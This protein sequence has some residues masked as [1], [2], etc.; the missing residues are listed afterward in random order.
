MW[1]DA[2]FSSSYLKNTLVIS[3]I[4]H[5]KAVQSAV[6]MHEFHVWRSYI[7]IH[8]SCKRLSSTYIITTSNASWPD[9]S[10]V[11][12]IYRHCRRKG[13]EAPGRP[14]CFRPYLLLLIAKIIQWKFITSSFWQ[15]VWGVQ[16]T[17]TLVWLDW[18]KSFLGVEIFY[19]L[20]DSWK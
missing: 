15:F 4:I 7:Q 20:E 18:R 2:N 14:G 6:Q 3:R 19:S 17:D 5:R 12:R 1:K 16:L 9:G 13:F 11:R 8:L 10:T